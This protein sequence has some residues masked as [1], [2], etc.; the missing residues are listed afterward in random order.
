MSNRTKDLIFILLL[1]LTI[2][3]V[4]IYYNFSLGGDE[5]KHTAM[6]I[7][8]WQGGVFS[9]F[10]HPIDLPR[11]FL[12]IFI[13]PWISLTYLITKDVMLAAG[14]TP[15]LF[16]TAVVLIIYQICF[17]LYDRKTAIWAGVLASLFPPLVLQSSRLLPEIYYLFCICYGILF[18]VYFFEKRTLIN[19]FL[20]SLFF[21]M[22]ARMHIE[23]NLVFLLL[24]V[25]VLYEACKWK[26]GGLIP[27]RSLVFM[28][29]VMFGTLLT[30]MLVELIV[31]IKVIHV[32]RSSSSALIGI[33]LGKVVH[34]LQ[35]LF[36][37]K[38]PGGFLQSNPFQYA[39]ENLHLVWYSL[40]AVVFDLLK[41]IFLI[42]LRIIPPLLLIVFGFSFSNNCLSYTQKRIET[43][44]LLML[45]T[46]LVFPVLLIAELRYFALLIP[47]AIIFLAKGMSRFSDR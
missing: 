41:S 9:G 12:L 34:R 43:F 26:R 37:V 24:V 10:F 8:I 19:M 11:L 7:S 25:Y 16:G 44:L 33:L 17:R 40:L 42:P 6:A 5:V 13:S 30:I 3:L 35:T 14:I 22:A 45:P 36:L 23:G 18:L 46:L 2:R 31:A 32:P 27:P 4:Y 15:F 39:A 28:A 29:A 20:A 38:T 21:A 1:A 47:V